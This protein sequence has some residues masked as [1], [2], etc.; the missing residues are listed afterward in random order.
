MT[1]EVERTY[2]IEGPGLPVAE[3]YRIDGALA[4]YI[5]LHFGSQPQE[6]VNFVRAAYSFRP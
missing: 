3:G 2:N 4:S 1:P 6:A 5:H